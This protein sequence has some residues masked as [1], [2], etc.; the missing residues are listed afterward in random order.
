MG[1]CGL[2]CAFVCH[3]GYMWP[4]ELCVY[5]SDACGSVWLCEVCVGGLREKKEEQ[6]TLIATYCV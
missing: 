4:L 1:T 6:L 5:V 3:E 2:V